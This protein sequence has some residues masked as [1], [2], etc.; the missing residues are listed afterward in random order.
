MEPFYVAGFV[1]TITAL[2]LGITV[3]E[4]AHAITADRLGDDTPR[5]Q[6]RVTLWPLAHLDP[7]G[8]V[9]MIVTALLGYGVGWGRPVE[10]N[11]ANY[12]SHVRLRLFLVTL[13][14][15]FSNLVLAVIFALL[16]RSGVFPHDDAFQAWTLEITRINAL[17]CLFNLL[18]LYPLDGSRLLGH[19][20][21][22]DMAEPYW[23]FMR[24]F[25]FMLFILFAM[26]SLTGRVLTPAVTAL[27][28]VLVG[29]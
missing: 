25:G 13:A 27:M 10:T 11:P 18:P 3:H 17:L 1:M 22:E 20:L 8:T 2:I 29:T 15:P 21:P 14:G 28:R 9:F 19:S 6:G 7:I 26:T 24:T 4:W 5:R 12:Q 23:R 16:Y